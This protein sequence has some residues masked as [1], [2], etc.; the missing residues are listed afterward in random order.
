MIE[1]ASLAGQYEQAMAALLGVLVTAGVGMIKA[2]LSSPNQIKQM[3]KENV[4]RDAKLD[5]L[6]EKMDR[7]EKAILVIKTKLE[8]GDDS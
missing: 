2:A 1:L 6:F 4:M 5:K 3:E 7:V 8:H